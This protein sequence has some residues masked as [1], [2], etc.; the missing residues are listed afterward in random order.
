MI[1]TAYTKEN[2]EARET[3]ESP[4]EGIPRVNPVTC[5]GQVFNTAGSVPSFPA[6]LSIPD[7]AA[8]SGR[9]AGLYELTF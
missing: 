2:G 5:Q 1:V 6:S 8:W 7:S 3:V 9:D 4:D